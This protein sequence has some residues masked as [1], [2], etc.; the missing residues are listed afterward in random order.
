MIGMGDF[1]K[2]IDRRVNISFMM[3]PATQVVPTFLRTN[4]GMFG[5]G[6]RAIGNEGQYVSCGMQMGSQGH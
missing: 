4:K 3:S 5:L 6:A 1:E 2:Q